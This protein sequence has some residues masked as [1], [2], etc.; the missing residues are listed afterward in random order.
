MI[1]EKQDSGI[2]PSKPDNSCYYVR[3]IL[4]VIFIVITLYYGIINIANMGVENGI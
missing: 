1:P 3:K 4:I 2:K